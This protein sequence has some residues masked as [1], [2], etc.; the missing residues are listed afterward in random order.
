MVAG[1]KKV[2]NTAAAAC[3]S[4]KTNGWAGKIKL[5]IKKKP[6]AYAE[7][8]ALKESMKALEKGDADMDDVE[9]QPTASVRKA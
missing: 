5:T 3:T 7:K 6:S 1:A 2:K 9:V 8:K 4:R